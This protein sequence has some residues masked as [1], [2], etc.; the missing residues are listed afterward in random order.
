MVQRFSALGLNDTILMG[1]FTF[2]TYL[3][4]SLLVVRRSPSQRWSDCRD[5]HRWVF[6]RLNEDR[7]AV[8]CWKKPFNALWRKL[9]IHG[10]FHRLMAL[11]WFGDDL[12]SLD[13]WLVNEFDRLV[14]EGYVP[15]SRGWQGS[16]Q[17][18]FGLQGLYDPET[19]PTL[20]DHG[21]NY[22]VGFQEDFIREMRANRNAVE[23]LIQM[24][25][26][27]VYME[28]DRLRAEAELRLSI[29]LPF[30]LLMIILSVQ[31]TPWMAFL[32]IVP[33]LLL[34]DGDRKM[35]EVEEKTWAPVVAGEVL[36]PFQD[37]IK[38]HLSKPV[39]NF[40]EELKV[41]LARDEEL[42]EVT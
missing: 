36:T 24:K 4:G 7:D 13:P 15:V 28:L 17:P 14:E 38:D 30:T 16:C 35:R 1:A 2:I 5:H 42:D 34:R 33:L 10:P 29:F 8:T 25:T 32:L 27:D 22:F 31:W 18:A 26:P 40:Q 21:A 39:R 20:D 41:Y 6:S 37:Q 9:V 3:V 19:V 23:V 11:E 12:S